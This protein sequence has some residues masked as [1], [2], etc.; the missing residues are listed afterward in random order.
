MIPLSLLLRRKGMQAAR[1][2]ASASQPLHPSPAPLPVLQM[3][4]IVA[5]VACCVAMAMPQVHMIAYC[6]DLGYS[7]ASGAEMLSIM[8]GLGVV[9]RLISG[10][11]ADRIGGLGTLLLGSSLQCMALLLYLPFDGLASLYLVAALFG[12]PK[13]ASC[14]AMP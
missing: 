1:S 13:G 12:L 14:Q 6:L 3:F 10:L 8:L 4:L 9:S 11:L 5:G 7:A 2:S